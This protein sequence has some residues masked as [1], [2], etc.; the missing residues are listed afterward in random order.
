[1]GNPTQVEWIAWRGTALDDAGEEP[2]AAADPADQA[3]RVLLLVESGGNR[4]HLAGH[5]QGR[6][7]IISPR[8]GRLPNEPFDLVVV[9][10]A[11]FR[12]WHRQLVDAKLRDQP[13][14]LP[15]ILIAS[16]RD[17]R[18]RLKL[19][20]DTIDE[21]ILTPIEPGEFMERVE[22]LF[23][24]RRLA[25][26]QRARLAYVVNHDRLSGLPNLNLFMDRLTST[27]MDASVLNK[28]LYATV[29]HVPLAHVLAS[30]GH[31]EFDRAAAVCASRIRK[32]LGPGVP[33]AQLGSEKWGVIHPVGM[34]MDGVLEVC[35]RIQNLA[36]ESIRIDGERIRVSPRIGVG[37]YPQDASDAAGVLD[38][39]ISA[40]A[41]AGDAG[42]MFYSKSDQD[43]ALRFIRTE[44][45]LHE[46][47]KQEQFELWYQPQLCLEDRKIV[48]V[49]ALVRWRLPDGQLVPP[50]D[51]MEVAETTGLIC[52]IDRWVL[53]EAC[54]AV[55]RWREQGVG[56]ERVAV[57]VSAE[58]VCAADF[59]D[60][61]EA[62]LDEFRIPAAALELELTETALFEISGDSLDKL[63]RLRKRGIDIAVD[64]FGT[65]YSSL[66]YLHQLPVTSLKIDKAFVK[67]V[68]SNETNAAILRTIALLAQNFGLGT[69]A[70]G[71]EAKEEAAYLASL[72]VSV[73][74]GYLYAKPMPEAD[75]LKWLKSR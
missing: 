11:G 1:M 54:A 59:A 9:D 22:M 10:A 57:N 50:L 3:G 14:F 46:A 33:L 74:Q 23:R 15:V 7:H 61:I 65:G 62:T 49:E 70:E 18:R 5:L 36:G 6:H 73:G 56:I 27:I 29:V 66:R 63:N 17:L 48:A 51:F 71:I 34:Q 45:R 67:N 42:P 12:R 47:L 38:C 19:F 32:L 16:R 75:L 64:D 35:G 25:L 58:D 24:A 52:D 60:V 53:R 21:F 44:S 31:R 30:L 28:P 8:G 2:D 4:N 26:K 41:A 39:A 13:T 69:V 68:D 20:W 40:L 55:K 72:N 37:A 43:K